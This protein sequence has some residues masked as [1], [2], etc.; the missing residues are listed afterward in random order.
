MVRGILER[1]YTQK[2]F[3]ESVFGETVWKK[4][5]RTGVKFDKKNLKFVQKY[6][7]NRLF[8]PFENKGPDGLLGRVWLPEHTHF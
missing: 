8:L 3:G 7:L 5:N 6:V 1:I 2:P 4:L